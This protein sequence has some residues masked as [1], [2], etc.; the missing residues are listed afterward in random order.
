VSPASLTIP[1]FVERWR[2][3][4]SERSQAQP[5]FID[6]CHA[7]GEPT[8][9]ERDPDANFY[10]FEKR[11]SQRKGGKGFAD[12]WY[13]NH[14][15]W[16]YK[17]ADEDLEKAYVQLDEYR[18]DL[19]NP[20]LLV[21]C[22]LQ[23]F[24]V[25]TNFTGTKK[26]VYKFG[27]T[28]L[29]SNQPLPDCPLP[30][31]DVLR[32]LFENPEI[33]HPVR[34]AE[35]VTELA[36][37]QFAAL[38]QGL[39]ATGA[40]P[41]E[42]ARFLIR[43]LFCLFAEDI[44]LLPEQVFTR[45]VEVTRTRPDEFRKRVEALFREMATGGFFGP[46]DIPYFNGGLFTDTST[47]P[48]TSKDLFVLL[49]ACRLD[50][51]HV[52]PAI[53][54]TLFER[55]LD[56]QKRAQIGAHYTSRADILLIVEPVLM[57]PLRRTWTRV[58]QDVKDLVEQRDKAS[59]ATKD[60]LTHEVEDVQWSFMQDIGHVRVLDPACGSGNFLYVA[61][62]ELL[63]LSKE[64]AVLAHEL[65]LPSITL[66]AGPHQLFGL[67]INEYA[68]ELAQIVVWIGYIQWLHD[69]GYS[70]DRRP[71]LGPQTTIE[72][73][74]AILAPENSGTAIDPPWP[75]ADI[76]IGNPPF[77]GGKR[78]RAELGDSDVNKLFEQ[79]Q[80]RVAREADL[81]CYFFERAREQV[82]QGKAQ[83]VGLL[84]TNSIRGGA[85]R[86]V[87]QRIKET[88]DI[89]MAWGDRPWILDGAAVRVSMVGFDDG[90]E[91]VRTL[92]GLPA[93]VINPDLTTALDLTS[94]MR[95]PENFNIA[96][97]GDTKGG[98]F[99]IS[100]QVATGMLRAPLNPNDRPNS[101]VVRP[102]VNGLDITRRP[103]DM[104][105]IDF[106]TS[107][108]ME[109]AALYESPF[110]YIEEN[111][112]PE[113]LKNNRAAYRERWW[114]HVE[115]R[116]ALRA[117]IDSL[118]RFVGTPTVAKHRLFVW[119]RNPTL[120]DH[121][122]IVI[123]RSDDYFLG[124]LQSRLHEAW[125]L[126]L[127]THLGVGNDPR[128]TPS[129]TFETFPFPWSPGQEPVD[130]PRV[131]SIASAA[132]NLV[133]QRD[134]WLN[135]SGASDAEVKSRTLTNLYNQRPMWLDLAH[136]RLDG[137]VLDAYGWPH[138]LADDQI[139]QRLL[140]LNQERAGVPIDQGPV[141]VA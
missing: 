136:R 18:A 103:R 24:E 34:A 108:P 83:R 56:P 32:A 138:D 123:A 33:L 93:I 117:A 124:V 4:K 139:L 73:R 95:L 39:N 141:P 62:K 82:V 20:P 78:L 80:G 51:S 19:E 64:V 90:Q 140:S 41:S 25:H 75:D 100:A 126:R 137:A 105:I 85:N 50:W 10:M 53:F 114:I 88:G 116:P 37:R 59:G 89:F 2:L 131:I 81:V 70:N 58:Q 30:P 134:R 120:P 127:G 69:N 113:R 74:D 79:Y 14:F 16:E 31:L 22:D 65:G 132:T 106:G 77:L 3:A 49:E 129:T 46:E 6:L 47:L 91:K 11:V 94:A 48:L 66:E 72:R 97:M 43:I 84:A 15:G 115:P 99:D 102:W 57:S 71:I 27:L 135:P 104:W 12:V 29:L 122:L 9:Q 98:A 101:D 112:K 55:S 28:D 38:A 36:A 110:G 7:L 60:A 8:P 26:R 5:H 67:E 107:M 44:G 87:L 1:A 119:L 121:Q 40:P 54:G 130:D 42:I 125:A 45:L 111:V 61:L 76:I 133:E 13:L 109:Q 23:T 52:E 86:R 21:V 128:Y 118:P 63:D 68:H 96:F 17:S 92:D 35:H